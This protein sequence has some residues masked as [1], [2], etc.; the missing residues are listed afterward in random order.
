MFEYISYRSFLQA[1]TALSPDDQLHILKH[2]REK[3]NTNSIMNKKDYEIL[4]YYLTEVILDYVQ[5]LILVYC[6]TI[7]YCIL[8]I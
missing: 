3:E 4:K 1:C 7:G 6:I 2:M 5:Y 8:I